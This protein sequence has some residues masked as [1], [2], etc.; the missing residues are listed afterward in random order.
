M[1]GKRTNGTKRN[2]QQGDRFKPKIILITTLNVNDWNNKARLQCKLSQ[3]VCLN[4]KT[5]I[6]ND[7]YCVILLLCG[8]KKY[9]KLV[10]K[11]KK[12]QTHRYRKQ[13]GGYQWG[14]SRAKG[15]TGI[16]D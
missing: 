11:T 4:I 14:E 6:E 13:T 10:T 7:E 8:S 1:K 3:E 5:Q 12:K 16:G 15:N 9:N 2:K